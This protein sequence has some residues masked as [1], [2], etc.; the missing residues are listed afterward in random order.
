MISFRSLASRS[1]TRAQER[2]LLAPMSGGP[3]QRDD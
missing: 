3:A 1:E 2:A